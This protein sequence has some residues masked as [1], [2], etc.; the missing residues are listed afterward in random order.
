[1]TPSPRRRGMEPRDIG[2]LGRLGKR[3]QVGEREVQGLLDGAVDC[4]EHG[5]SIM[6]HL[7]TH[8]RCDQVQLVAL[9]RA[10]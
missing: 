2:E 9:A 7:R 8:V 10:R 3:R 6:I 1:M 4:Q 5:S